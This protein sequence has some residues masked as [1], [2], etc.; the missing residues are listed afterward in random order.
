MCLPKW[1]TNHTI[2]SESEYCLFWCF[3][4]SDAFNFPNDAIFTAFAMEMFLF[5]S[6]ITTN[7]KHLWRNRRRFQ[8]VAMKL[9]V[10]PNYGRPSSMSGRS[11][12]KS[13]SVKKKSIY[14]FFFL[15]NM[16]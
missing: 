11:T 6:S 12:I 9:K 16:V 10:H 8:H 14:F 5:I 1:R 3:V 13:D 15:E 2:G 7:E 4:P